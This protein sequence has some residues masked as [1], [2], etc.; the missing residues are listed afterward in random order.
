MDYTRKV[1]YPTGL[2][3]SNN[4][5]VYDRDP[6][7]ECELKAQAYQNQQCSTLNQS[8]AQRPA[9][10]LVSDIHN[11]IAAQERALRMIEELSAKVFGPTPE[12]NGKGEIHPDHIT[13]MISRS[14]NLAM[15]IADRLEGLN[16]NI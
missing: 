10:E 13:A 12:A 5:E 1:P 4:R 11:T 3:G 9:S 8:A 2:A 14:R 15:Q 6:I 7:A 16:A